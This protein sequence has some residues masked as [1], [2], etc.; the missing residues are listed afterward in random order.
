[1]KEFTYTESRQ[2]FKKVL[3]IAT[4]DHEAVRITRRNGENAILVAEE[5]Y[6]SLLETAYLLRSP[7]NAKRLLEARKRSADESVDYES[8]I[9]D[10]GI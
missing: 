7:Q 4:E 2:K 9:R 1:M 8:V 5:D 10:S 3:C 6:D